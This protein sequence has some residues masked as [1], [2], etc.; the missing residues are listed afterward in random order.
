MRIT[1]SKNDLR[2]LMFL[3]RR[4]EQRSPNGSSSV[5]FDLGPNEGE[6]DIS[7]PAPP[8]APHGWQKNGCRKNGTRQPQRLR[9]R[10]MGCF[11]FG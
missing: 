2:G 9:L 1:V 7:K 10:L 5:M 11:C 4:G 3:W 6:Q 8:H